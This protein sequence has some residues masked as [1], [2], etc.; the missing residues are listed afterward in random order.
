MRKTIIG[1]MW[2]WPNATEKEIKSWYEIWKLIA[3]E[4]WITLTGGSNTGIMDSTLHGAKD[5]GGITIGILPTKDPWKTSIYVDIPIYTNMG[6]GRNVINVLSSDIVI[7][8]GIGSWTASEISLALK[9]NKKIILYWTSETAEKFFR[10][11]W[12][13]NVFIAQSSQEVIEIIKN[14]LI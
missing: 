5:A 4:W 2:P 3:S 10:E 7:A 14:Q 8:C 6:S 12:K 13:E 9:E 11:I 1:V